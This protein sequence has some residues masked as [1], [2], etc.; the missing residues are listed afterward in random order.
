MI[1]PNIKLTKDI[2]AKLVADLFLDAVEND[3]D[4]IIRNNKHF[5]SFTIFFDASTIKKAYT[6]YRYLFTGKLTAHLQQYGYTAYVY[7]SNN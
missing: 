6:L 4:L 1:N 5:N 2:T 3:I 7:Y